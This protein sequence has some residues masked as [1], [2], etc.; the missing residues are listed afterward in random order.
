MELV[1]LA[2]HALLSPKQVLG[3]S[4]IVCSL[5]RFGEKL[6]IISI[7]EIT[8][9]CFVVWITWHLLFGKGCFGQCK[10]SKWVLALF[11]GLV[12]ANQPAGSPLEIQPVS[13]ATMFF[14]H[15]K[16][17][18]TVFFSQVLDQRTGPLCGKQVMD[19]KEGFGGPLVWEF[20]GWGSFETFLQ[21]ECI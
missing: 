16:P 18:G 11:A 10:L 2:F 12:P 4:D 21:K 5:I 1:R 17:A 19:R 6:Q 3:S 15:N 9:M 7:E 20:M 14:S 13:A 8:Q